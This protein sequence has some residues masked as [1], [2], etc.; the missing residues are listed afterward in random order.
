VDLYFSL[1]QKTHKGPKEKPPRLDI[2]LNAKKMIEVG[3][4]TDAII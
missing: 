1:D 2:K 3:R 4:S